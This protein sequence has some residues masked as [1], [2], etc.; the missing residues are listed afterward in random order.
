MERKKIK[1]QKKEKVTIESIPF[2]LMEMIL[3]KLNSRDVN[4]IL[5][6]SKQTKQIVDEYLGEE[7][8]YQ[9]KAE[10]VKFYTCPNYKV[11]INKSSKFNHS[12]FTNLEDKDNYYLAETEDFVNHS[13]PKVDIKYSEGKIEQI[14]E[15]SRTINDSVPKVIITQDIKDKNFD[16]NY[17]RQ[18]DFFID[19]INRGIFFISGEFFQTYL[20]D[21]DIDSKNYLFCMM[22]YESVEI[23]QRYD[24]EADFLV[25]IIIISRRGINLIEFRKIKNI[26][27]FYSSNDSF[28]IVGNINIYDLETYKYPLKTF[29]IELK[30]IDEEILYQKIFYFK[31]VKFVYGQLTFGMF[32]TSVIVKNNYIIH[33]DAFNHI[34]IVLETE[35]KEKIKRKNKTFNIYLISDYKGVDC[36]YLNDTKYN[37]I[38]KIIY[39]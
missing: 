17:M 11:Y 35:N 39:Q 37:Q 23:T 21:E 4:N 14:S 12:F 31:D 36:K 7:T 28:S 20:T 30:N 27:E 3:D 25:S 33:L 1:E 22:R 24:D 38:A 34:Y 5:K 18:K 13:S 9:K 10:K 6:T 29:M 8:L 16:R 15:F 2:E 32:E 26:K 19:Y